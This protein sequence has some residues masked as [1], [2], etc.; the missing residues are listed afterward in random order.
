MGEIR[1]RQNIGSC[2]IDFLDG[3][4]PIEVHWRPASLREM[5]RIEQA[6]KRGATAVVIETVLLRARDE[7]GVRIWSDKDRNHVETN[8][9]VD[10]AI[11]LVAQIH[12]TDES[13]GN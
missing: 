5:D 1:N 4:G 9:D 12:K 10:A 13:A 11:D 8:I 6:E 3:N 7:S 2:T